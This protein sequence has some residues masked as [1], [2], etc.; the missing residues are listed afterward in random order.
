[1]DE[2]FIKEH[3][4]DYRE[5]LMESL[6]DKEQSMLYL[7]TALEEYLKDGCKEAFLQA[8]YDVAEAQGN[9]S[10]DEK[11]D[12]DMEHTDSLDHLLHDLGFR[13]SI[14]PMDNRPHHS[15]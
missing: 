6:K 10:W 4:S 12:I 13:L 8:L 15:Y 7:E 1:M 11:D 3:T 9:I 5:W 2:K 14:A